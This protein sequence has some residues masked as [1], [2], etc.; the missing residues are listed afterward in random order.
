MWS[1]QPLQQHS[2]GTAALA[3]IPTDT[4]VTAANEKAKELQRA[5]LEDEE[6]L[7]ILS[8]LWLNTIIYVNT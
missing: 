7:E 4:L 1:F 5:T 3:E 8:I 2:I 6:R